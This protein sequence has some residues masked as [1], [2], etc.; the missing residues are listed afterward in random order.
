M[1]KKA[2]I[3][4]KTLFITAGEEYYIEYIYGSQRSS[5]YYKRCR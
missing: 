5:F 4:N 1:K 2:L 3:D